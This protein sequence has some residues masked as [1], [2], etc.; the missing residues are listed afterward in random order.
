MGNRSLCIKKQ[1]KD[2]DNQK[3]LRLDL[4]L[5]KVTKAWKEISN[6]G[7]QELH[8]KST[9]NVMKPKQV[10]TMKINHSYVC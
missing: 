4:G 1:D 9:K 7:S 2:V 5:D 8:G 10:R 6:V 3:I